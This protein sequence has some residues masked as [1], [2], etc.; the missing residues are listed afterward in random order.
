MTRV[1]RVLKRIATGNAQGIEQRRNRRIDTTPNTEAIL[2]DSSAVVRFPLAADSIESR[3][4]RR[5]VC[6]GT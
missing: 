5:S 6:R 1:S 3:P 4:S 2:S